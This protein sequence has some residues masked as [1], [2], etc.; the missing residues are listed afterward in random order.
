MMEEI[1]F[2][3]RWGVILQYI[4]MGLGIVIS[5]IYT[6]IM[7][8]VLGSAE[9]GIYNLSNSIISYLSLLSL[10]FAAS[11]I[12]YYSRYKKEDNIERINKLNGLFL[13]IFLLIGCI[14]LV[15][16]IA[17]SMNVS[18]F[19]NDTY[20]IAEKKIA[21]ILMV[22]MAFNLATSFPTSVF[23][24]YVTAQERF[25]FQKLLNMIKT[26]VGPFL[27]LP[28]LLLGYGSV[29]MVII[30]TCITLFADITN[31]VFCIN[32]LKMKF[33]FRKTDPELIKE[34]TSFSIFIAINQI[35]DQINWATDKVILGKICTGT[36]VAYYAIGSQINS[37]FTNFSTA[38]S[39]VFVP[40]IHRIQ[41]SDL[42]DEEKNKIHTELFTKIGR[43]Q[44]MILALIL[45]GFFFFGKFFVLTWAGKDYESS[46]YVALLLMTPAL[47]PLIQNAGIEIQQ[48]KNKHQFRSLVYLVM[49]FGNIVISVF[50]ARRWGEIGAAVGTTISLVV[51]N[52]VIMNIFYHKVIKLDI[53]FFWKQIGKFIP[54]LIFPI[55][56]GILIL[57]FYEFRGV[58][59][60]GVLVVVYF[61]VYC[62]SMYFWGMNTA[63]KDMIYLMFK[64]VVKK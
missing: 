29:G 19:F 39:N 48:A 64:K 58:I 20:T 59:D 13:K 54:A 21:Q 57:E 52:G 3:R 8:R 30:T 36:A 38:I 4:Q 47:V 60:F 6:P 42:S 28:V 14:A 18:L 51:A 45:S 56:V 34:I 43:I 63:E 53:I 35:I 44:F 16:G 41:N 50:L 24:A 27:T 9:F 12:R 46:Y 5:L 62:C 26:V 15:A 31:I 22:F 2:N 33:D 37:Y 49:A 55:T 11:Y 7:L 17:L 61:I 25:V 10:G 1:N 32:K 23:V 40:Q